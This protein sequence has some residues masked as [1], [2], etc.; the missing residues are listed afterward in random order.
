MKSSE[1]EIQQKLLEVRKELLNSKPNHEDEDS[2]EMSSADEDEVTFVFL[3]QQLESRQLT[4]LSQLPI[5][6]T[7]ETLQLAND[8]PA[9]PKLFSV[10]QAIGLTT[11]VHFPAS[12]YLIDKSKVNTS[13]CSC[14]CKNFIAKQITVRKARWR[15]EIRKRQVTGHISHTLTSCLSRYRCALS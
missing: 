15:N 14:T 4:L 6:G 5:E 8:L 11:C 13:S 9:N 1:T 12:H 2:E 7:R 10:I 3:E